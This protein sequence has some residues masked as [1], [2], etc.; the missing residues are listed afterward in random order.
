MHIYYLFTQTKVGTLR[1]EVLEVSYRGGSHILY[2]SNNRDRWWIKHFKR[3]FFEK[4]VADQTFIM[5]TILENG[6]GSNI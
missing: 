3:E 4:P 2:G 6:G 5:V 1:A